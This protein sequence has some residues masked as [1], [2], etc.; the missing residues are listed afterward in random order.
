[1]NLM[2]GDLIFLSYKSRL[3]DESPIIPTVKSY[4]FE[5]FTGFGFILNV[6]F[7]DPLYVSNS[8]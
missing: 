3:D 4:S 8:F 5:N 1:M 7:S 2:I 6:S